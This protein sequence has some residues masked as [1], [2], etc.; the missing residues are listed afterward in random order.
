M[1]FTCMCIRKG[2]NWTV[3][4]WNKYVYCICLNYSNHRRGFLFYNFLIFFFFYYT[5]YTSMS[6]FS[7][8]LLMILLLLLLG[9]ALALTLATHPVA[10]FTYNDQLKCKI[11]PD[12]LGLAL[13]YNLYDSPS[14]LKPLKVRNREVIKLPRIS[15]VIKYQ[16]DSI[17]KIFL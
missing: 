14:S 1:I 15:P 11:K 16:K 3:K 6:G 10:S 17:Q 13:F 8:L 4:G 2:E 12:F 7:A 9:F 5:K